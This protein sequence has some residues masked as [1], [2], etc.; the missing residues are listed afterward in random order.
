MAAPV[1][2]RF[3]TGLPEVMQW[4][5]ERSLAAMDRAGV[6]LAVL[7]GS[8]PGVDF[9]RGLADVDLARRCNGY[10]AD[11]VRAHPDRFR[12]LTAL[13]MPQAA[14]A[15]AEAARAIDTLG[16]KGVAL[17]SHYDG[18]YLG[19]PAFASVFDELNRRRAIVYVHPN[20][21]HY[22]AG[23][24]AGIPDPLI[25][26]PVDTGRTIA[27]L[28]WSGTLS[29]CPASASCSRTAAAYTRWSPR[30][31]RWSAR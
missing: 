5:P 25:E 4:T 21:P 17:L 26:L 2:G 6:G 12:F 28:L 14:P 23:V 31:C 16:A 15:V 24:V 19:D 1:L 18:R 11:L 8:A 27:S 9:G 13:P 29:R 30:G 3:A 10:M 7:S 22:P 20:A